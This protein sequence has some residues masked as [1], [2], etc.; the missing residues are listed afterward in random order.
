[1]SESDDI[2]RVV[3]V[4]QRVPEKRLRLIDLANRIP[5]KNGDFDLDVVA[6]LADEI[7]LARVEAAA[8]GSATQQA[9]AAL[10][11]LKGNR[12]SRELPAATNDDLLEAMTF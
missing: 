8:Y 10:T 11:K 4:L 1:M 3:A 6:E 12:Q 5:L 2:Q 9:V 7:N